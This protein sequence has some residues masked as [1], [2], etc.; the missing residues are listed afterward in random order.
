MSLGVAKANEILDGVK[1]IELQV[2]EFRSLIDQVVTD[3]SNSLSW[4]T[5]SAWR[6][7][8]VSLYTDSL[9][10]LKCILKDVKGGMKLEGGEETQ[11]WGNFLGLE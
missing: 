5:R 6:S 3:D 9:C 8:R 10:N 2:R 1:N 4:A 11:E 7:D